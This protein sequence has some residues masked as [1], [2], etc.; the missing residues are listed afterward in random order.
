MNLPVKFGGE[1]LLFKHSRLFQEENIKVY[2]NVIS[3]G[4]PPAP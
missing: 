1:T 3:E 2:F 4:I